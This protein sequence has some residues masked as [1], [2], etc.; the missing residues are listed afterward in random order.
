MRTLFAASIVGLILA[1]PLLYMI[2]YGFG[3]FE[4]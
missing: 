1:I 2:D 4:I 3:R